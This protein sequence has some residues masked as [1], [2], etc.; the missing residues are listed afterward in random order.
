MIAAQGH[1]GDKAETYRRIVGA[2]AID[3][4]F[5]VLRQDGEPAAWPMGQRT[6][7]SW[8]SNQ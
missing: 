8:S 3:A 5:V 6:T 4:A 7:A 1:T 2:I